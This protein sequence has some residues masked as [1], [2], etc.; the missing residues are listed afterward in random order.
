MDFVDLGSLSNEIMDHYF[1]FSPMGRLVDLNHPRLNYVK[2]WLAHHWPQEACA[3]FLTKMHLSLIYAQVVFEKDRYDVAC[4]LAGIESFP[5][6]FSPAL[7][8]LNIALD[9]LDELRENFDADET[10]SI[11][12]VS[13]C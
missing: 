4:I 5:S 6:Y 3:P 8:A 9:F 1:V 12:I 2:F 11:S 7:H 10:E 13:E